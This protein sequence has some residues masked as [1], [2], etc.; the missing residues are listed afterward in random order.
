L[1]SNF[2]P[3]TRSLRPV[4]AFFVHK[5]AVE[6]NEILKK[7]IAHTLLSNLGSSIYFPKGVIAQSSE[8]EQSADLYNASVGMAT[9]HRNPMHLDAIKTHISGLSVKEIFAYAPTAG[10]L[11][12]RKVWKDIMTQKNPALKDIATSLP[13]VT[14]GITHAVAM[15]ADLFA[16]EG[17]TVLLPEM[18]WDNYKLLFE[19]RRKAL[20]IN[21]PFYKGQKLNL[22]AM[23]QVL[24]TVKSHKLLLVLNFPHNPTGYSPTQEEAF[25]LA[26]ILLHSAQNGKQIAVI[27]DDAY[28]GLFYEQTTFKQSLFG[29]LGGL[30]KNI[31]A[32]KADGATKEDLCWGL[33]IGFITFAA[34]SLQ[35]DHYTALEKKVMGALRS[36]I[37]SCCRLSQSLLFKALQSSRYQEEKDNIFSLLKERYLAVKRILKARA[38]RFLTPLPFN[39]GYFLTFACHDI[40]AE[41][42]RVH[43]LSKLG[44]GT[45]A[46]SPRLLRVAYSSLNT[47]NITGFFKELWSAAADIAQ[48]IKRNTR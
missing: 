26:D 36:S 27:I 12:L 34:K 1:F 47:E 46:I 32:I 9:L 23:Q 44:I 16:D 8:A 4:Y 33:R 42:L 38:C 39:S 10:I 7:T 17:D 19:V 14:S 20:L 13:I 45:I 31:L 21:Y 37:S 28:F 18:F 24:E 48:K 35:Q 30:H 5:L 41:Q 2:P 3:L 15:A 6:L 11:E 29:L 43:L 40:N 22:S 25:K